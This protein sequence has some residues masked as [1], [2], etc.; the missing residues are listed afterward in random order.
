MKAGTDLPLCCIL[1][2]YSGRSCCIEVVDGQLFSCPPPSCACFLELR[3]FFKRARHE[4]QL[5][6]APVKQRASAG[7]TL[8][9]LQEQFSKQRIATKVLSPAAETTVVYRT[10]ACYDMSLKHLLPLVLQRLQPRAGRGPW[11]W[12]AW[13]LVLLGRASGC[14]GCL[15]VVM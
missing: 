13:R 3:D 11:G 15:S 2:L 10:C 9:H 7:R 6:T 5:L 12:P 14:W 1:L 4:W 8:P